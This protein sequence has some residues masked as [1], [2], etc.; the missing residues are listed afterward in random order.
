MNIEIV[1]STS[2]DQL[3]N[4]TVTQYQVPFISYLYILSVMFTSL[5]IIGIYKFFKYAKE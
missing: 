2:T 4:T 5:L 3:G 1:T